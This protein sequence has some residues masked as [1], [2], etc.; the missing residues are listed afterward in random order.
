M[1]APFSV[2]ARKKYKPV[3][4][5]VHLVYTKLPEQYRIKRKITRDPLVDLPTLNLNPGG[6]IPT[7]CYTAERKEIIDTLHKGKFLWPEERKLM[8]MHEL[9]MIHEKRIHPE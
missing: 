4:L 1:D 9:M 2:F 6:F 5:K 3:G 7:G 8:L